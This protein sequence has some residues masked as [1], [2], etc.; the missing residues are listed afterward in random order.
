MEY[1]TLLIV[2]SLAAF[3]VVLWFKRSKE[4]QPGESTPRVWAYKRKH[5]LGG[6]ERQAL[7]R[8][9][10]ALPEHTIFAQ[11]ALSCVVEPAE[12]WGTASYRAL[13]NSVSQKSVDFVIVD[14]NFWAVAVIEVDGPTH[15]QPKQKTRDADKDTILAAAGI[16]IERWDASRLPT[17]DTI[18][19]TFAPDPP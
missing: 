3:F 15:R 18:R 5:F 1:G 17:V 12:K 8:L 9:R 13:L 6:T 11:V 7:A 19:Q 10:E 4:V 14:T 2:A 16:R